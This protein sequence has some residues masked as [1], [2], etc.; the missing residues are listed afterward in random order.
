MAPA[1]RPTPSH[2]DYLA[3]LNARKAKGIRSDDDPAVQRQHDRGKMTARERIDVLFDKGS[4]IETDALV[5][6][7]M[8]APGFEENRPPGDSVVTGYGT[9]DGRTVFAYSQDFTVFGGTVSEAA[10][11][12]IVKVQDLSLK[13]GAPIVALNDSG[14]ARVQAGIS[15]LKGYGDIFLRNVLASGVVPQIAVM[16]GPTAGGAVYSPAIMDFTYMVEGVSFMGITGPD[17]V[18]TVTG[19]EISMEELGGARTHASVSGVAHFSVKGGEQTLNEVRSLLAFL[20]SNN[21]EDPPWVDTGD[22]PNRRCEGIEDLVPADGM[23]P[24]PVRR[25]IEKIVDN[26]DFLEIHALWAQNIVVGFGRMAGRAIGIVGNNP[27]SLAGS[28]DIDASRKAARFVRFCDCFNI[29]LVTLVDVTGYL[30]GTQQE[31]GAII[32]HGA[33][34]LYAYAEATVPKIVVILRK[35][36][37]GAYVA[38]SSKSLRADVNLAWP[39]SEI[40]VMGSAGAIDLI[41][42]RRIAEADDPEAERQRLLQE[43]EGEFYNPY[44][45]A[46]LGFVD[47]VID[48]ADTRRVIVRS[49]EML[50]DKADTTPPKKHGNVPL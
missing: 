46:S 23:Q 19:E 48:P 31:H 41:Y 8:T 35:A 29:P 18:K 7:R 34:L 49:L 11:E 45:A 32:T 17:I 4:F 6:H 22:D 26:G 10:A 43:Y 1:D 24:Y 50:Q 42:R 3:E 25:V 40:A 38:M 39:G 5:T 16:L 37:G 14:G 9:V 28:L 12:K 21:M 2:A 27:E 15:G 44:Q 20:P 13:V 47:D 30:P 33:K 36:Y